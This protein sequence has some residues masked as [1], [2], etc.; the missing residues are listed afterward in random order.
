MSMVDSVGH[1]VG[2]TGPT[3]DATIGEADNMIGMLMD[4]LKARNL[5][6]C[7]N[8]IVVADHGQYVVTIKF[9]ENV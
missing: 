9:N 3:M 5:D 7:A 8:I 6:K 2:P 4:G 1:R